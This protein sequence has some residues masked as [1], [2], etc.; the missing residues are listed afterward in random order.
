LF[1]NLLAFD[2]YTKHDPNNPNF[3]LNCLKTRGCID[4][5]IKYL[6]RCLPKE[7]RARMEEYYASI[8]VILYKLA[9]CSMNVG[10]TEEERDVDEKLNDRQS[11][12]SLDTLRH[13][14]LSSIGCFNCEYVIE[15]LAV[16]WKEL[17]AKIE[18]DGFSQTLKVAKQR[19]YSSLNLQIETLIIV[20]PHLL[21]I[22]VK[23]LSHFATNKHFANGLLDIL[24]IFVALQHPSCQQLYGLI[25]PLFVKFVCE[26][27]DKTETKQGQKCKD[28]IVEYIAA[29][30]ATNEN[31]LNAV[32][33]LPRSIVAELQTKLNSVT[34]TKTKSSEDDKKAKVDQT[35]GVVSDDG[36][37]GDNVDKEMDKEKKDKRKK[38]KKKKKKRKKVLDT[39]P[40]PEIDFG[41]F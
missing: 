11:N 9:H 22:C 39:G 30:I 40:E 38:K 33:S 8:V 26:K 1:D 18:C 2:L 15:A 19:K 12:E 4:E 6:L 3:T 25:V 13:F 29:H 34:A 32:K 28:L 10:I 36:N 27:N 31:L 24:Q 14:V 7:S 23:D 20:L 17:L 41:A 35:D 16:C 21:M 5:N 37:K